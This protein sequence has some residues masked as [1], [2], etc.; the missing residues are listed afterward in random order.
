MKIHSAAF[1]AVMFSVTTISGACFAESYPSK[2][3]RLIVPS[4][5]GSSPDVRGRWLAEKLRTGLGQP[6]IIDNKPGA[7]GILGTLAMTQSRPDGYTILLSHQGIM[8]LNPHLYSNLPY[9]PLKDLI[10]VSRLVVSPMILVVHPDLPVRSVADLVRLAKEKPG[11]LNFGS[12]GVGTPPHM[13]GDLFKR[14]AHIDITTVAY[15]TAS[16]MLIDLLGGR[17]TYTFDGPAAVL[18]H[19]HGGTLRPLAVTS[20]KRVPSLPDIPAVAETFPG[21]EYWA[22]MGICVPAGTPKDIVTRLN[23]EMKRILSTQ[24]ARDWFAEQ[25]GEP[26]VETPEEFDAYIRKEHAYWGKV[27][28][29]AGMK[30]E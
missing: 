3:I 23:L 8:A 27:I 9:D 26:I 21:F 7:S 13:A 2:P 25:G 11:H 20:P 29:E 6:I 22:W 24:E 30:I 1:A 16:P 19:I 5:P 4:G 18:Q 10:P 14:S 17:L 12:P 15:K 28:R